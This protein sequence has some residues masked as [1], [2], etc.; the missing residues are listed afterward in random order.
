MSLFYYRRHQFRQCPILAISC[1][2]S[3]KWHYWD[4]CTLFFN[5][6]LLE[7]VSHFCF[8][9]KVCRSKQT[10]YRSQNHYVTSVLVLFM[11]AAVCRSNS[12]F[13]MCTNTNYAVRGVHSS[14]SNSFTGPFDWQQEL[15]VI[16]CFVCF[17]PLLLR[18]SNK[19]TR[20]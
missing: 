5:L 7:D 15:G 13:V 20:V 16:V 4:D 14:I 1:L 11:L 17:I 12:W 8:H 19:G 3:T 9:H 10:L 18:Y 2:T 6:S